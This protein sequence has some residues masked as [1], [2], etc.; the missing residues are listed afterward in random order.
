MANDIT[1]ARHLLYNP[2]VNALQ[3]HINLTISSHHINVFRLFFS[4]QVRFL[5]PALPTISLS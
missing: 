2:Q 4:A 5:I 1:R 3:K